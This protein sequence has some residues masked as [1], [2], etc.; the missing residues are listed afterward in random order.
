LLSVRCAAIE[1]RARAR[2]SLTSNILTF[3]CCAQDFH[4]EH[5]HVFLFCTSRGSIKLGDMR[6][7]ALCDR[8]AKVF[9]EEEDP[10]S[11]SYFSEIIA[12]VSD[13]EFSRDGRLIVARDV[14]SLAQEAAFRM[15]MRTHTAARA[16]GLPRLL[17]FLTAHMRRH[18]AHSPHAVPHCQGL[19]RGYGGP[20]ACLRRARARPAVSLTGRDGR[21]G[22]LRRDPASPRAAPSLALPSS[23]LAQTAEA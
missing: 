6:E 16:C 10:A 1:E 20:R 13:A 19:G 21:G 12:S 14:R 15:R 3:S 9:E 18:A 8:Q 7:A 5:S 22:R 11:K 23:A 2:A 4:P 17:A